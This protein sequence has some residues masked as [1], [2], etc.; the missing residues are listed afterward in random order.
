MYN[1]FLNYFDSNNI[2]SKNQFGFRKNHSTSLA[3]LQIL[4]KVSNAFDERKYTV[5]VF[6]DLSK[7]F[8]T[9]DH[10]ILFDKLAFYGVR[11]LP[12]DWLK[13]YFANRSQFVEYN[14]I[15]SS[16]STIT[17]GVPQ[18]S[19]LGPL[20]FL[21][22]INDICNVSTFID[23]V[24]FADDTNMFFSHYDLNTLMSTVNSEL[25]K[26]ALWFHANKLTINIKKTNYILFGPRQRKQTLDLTLYVNDNIIRQVSETVYLGVVLDEHLSWKPHVSHIAS[27]IS[28][29]IGV[30]YKSSF[31]L[32]KSALLSL[33]YSLIYPYLQYC[34]IV[35]GSTYSTNLNRIFLLQKRAVR[36]ICKVSYDEHT[37]SLFKNLRILKFRD[38]YLLSLGK[39]MYSFSKGLLPTIFND[40]FALSNEIHPYDTRSSKLFHIP[41]CRTNTRQFSVSY[42]GPNFFNSL[43]SDLRTAASVSSFQFQ[44]KQHLFSKY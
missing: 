19:I 13:N 22:Y 26:L 32:P 23:L 14:G 11:G 41:Y 42:Q 9:V 8:D 6:L 15:S 21:I 43:S 18:G 30:I 12:L 36:I 20:L 7:A 3:L 39:F 4:D 34:I 27:K 40:F 16:H 5:G 17:C 38:T 35:W 28:K 24:L 44:L 2:L 1:R 29:S 25:N 37:N 10:N 33:Y 31:C